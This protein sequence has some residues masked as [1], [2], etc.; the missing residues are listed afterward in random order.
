MRRS[1]T[2][3]L[4]L[5]VALSLFAAPAFATG[6]AKTPA[7]PKNCAD[8]CKFVEDS[9]KAPCKTIKSKKEAQNACASQCQQFASACQSS[10]RE[11]GYIDKQH[12]IDRISPP[13]PP[14][15][16]NTR[17]EP[18]GGHEDASAGGH[19]K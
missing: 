12:I 17:S 3:P 16:T 9:C 4:H 5:L 18:E 7:R 13:K 14:P 6:P 10:C 8:Q 1:M 15:G 2:V 19:P 11:K